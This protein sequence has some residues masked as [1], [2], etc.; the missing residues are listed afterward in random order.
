MEKTQQTD[1][2]A[3]EREMTE[4]GRTFANI[5]W[6]GFLA[7]FSVLNEMVF[8][9]SL[10]DIAKQFAL[11]PGTANW[12]SISFV[13]T[14][15]I[16]SAIYGKLSDLYGVKKLL[17]IGLLVYNGGS[18]LGLLAQASFPAVVVARLIQGAGAASVPAMIMV[19]I[20]RYVGAKDRGKAFGLVGS[21][22]AFGEGIGPVIGGVIADCVHWSLLFTLPLMTL[23]SLPFFLKRLPDDKPVETGTVDIRGALLLSIGIVLFSLFTTFCLWGYLAAGLLVFLAFGRHIRRADQPFF[24]P[25]L[26][27]KRAFLFCTLAGGILL[28][29]MAGVISVVPYMMRDVHHLTTGM[30]GG[31]ILFPGTISVIVFGMVGGTLVDK[32]GHAFVMY[33]GITLLVT[34]FL[35]L[36]LL[37]D[38]AAWATAAGLVIAFAGLSFVKTAISAS[39]AER[40][41]EKD[42]GAGMGLLSLVCFVSEGMGVAIAGGVLSRHSLALPL[43]SGISQSAAPYSNLLLLFVLAVVIGGTVY[44]LSARHR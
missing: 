3:V 12:V 2:K 18:L 40:L 28:G 36:S 5:A 23:L 33:S 17:L 32:R 30:I 24:E 31:G 34:G 29:T 6:L 11:L 38:I 43:V 13:I 27:A 15:G 9:V 21:M 16:G 19:I 42:V 7:F 4:P 20:A 39:A 35:F 25:G 41:E 1:S 10:P 14:F 44:R 22:V 26:M 37:V 8:T